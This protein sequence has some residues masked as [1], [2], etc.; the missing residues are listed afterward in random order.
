M[1]L[2]FFFPRSWLGRSTLSSGDQRV[3]SIDWRQLDQMARFIPQ[4]SYVCA[5]AQHHTPSITRMRVRWRCSEKAL[6]VAQV[7]ERGGSW[8]KLWD[9]TLHLGT[10]YTTGLQAL[11]KV[12]A[13]HCHGSKP[14]PLCDKNMLDSSI[15]A[16][17]LSNHLDKLG[18]TIH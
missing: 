14:C 4:H 3:D 1:I 6:A 7:V 10:R 18:F 5:C 8:C 15:I 17:L 9:T 11:S 2:E 13:H 16:H 12:L